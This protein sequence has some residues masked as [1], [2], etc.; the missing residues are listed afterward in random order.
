MAGNAEDERAE[1]ARV[2]LELER[3][4]DFRGAAREALLAGDARRGAQLAALARDDALCDRAIDLVAESL[5]RDAGLHAAADLASRG[6]GRH[7]GALYTLLG[8]HSEAGAAFAS[9]GDACRAARS[10]EAAGRAAEGARALEAALRLRPSDGEARL[11]LGRLLARHGRTEAA[12]KTLQL[13]DTTA[14]ERRRALP[15][16]KNC[17]LELGLDEA[18]RSV[19]LEMSCAGI[20]DEP[21]EPVVEKAETTGPLMLGRYEPLREIAVTPHA[22]VVQALD[23]VTSERVAVKLLA[24]V[25]DGAGRDALFRFEREARALAQL[26]HPNI[27][28]LRAYHPEG[29]A[30]VLAWM[31]GGSLAT[32]MRA[33]PMAPA[34]SVEICCAVLSAL[35]E[36]HRLGILHRDVKPSNVLFDDVGAARLSD[37]GAAHLGDLSTTATAG[38]IGTFAYMSPEQ[39]LGRPATLTSDL[40]GVGVLLSE[41][42]TGH[43]LGPVTDQALEPRPSACHADL[44][45]SHDAVVARMLQENPARRPS[46]AFEARRLLQ[47]LRW[48]DRV[49]PRPAPQ[50]QRP[51]TSERPATSERGRL[52]PSLAVDD[53]RDR[54]HLMHDAWIDRDV[55]VLPWDADLLSRARAFA[56]AGHA[57]LPMILRADPGAGQIWIAPA[58]GRSLA[59]EPRGLSP[60][61]LARLREAVAA[62]HA[63]SGAHGQIDPEHLYWHDG[64]V[65]LAFPRGV[66]EGADLAER[67]RRALE[68]LEHGSAGDG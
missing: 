11:E 21:A 48:P 66:P 42:L 45:E 1:H 12:V 13:L 28:P 34:R 56:R 37:F 25:A 60:G 32:R 29:P 64:E 40:Y 5:S 43:P 49:Q 39:K 47:S 7:A 30:M 38:A 19:A 14:P 65:T 8:A 50:S 68:S 31:E 24:G 55:I 4:C 9:A 22:R 57:A 18:A 16:L 35:G 52:G 59:D 2:S 3:A 33:E 26:R 62:L 27:V 63:A 17:L 41:L 51:R 15:V 53:A 6:F 36:A 44:D 46:D 58:R 20:D 23:R 54:E 61:Q 10:F 67:D